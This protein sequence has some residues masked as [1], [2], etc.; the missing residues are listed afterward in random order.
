MQMHFKINRVLF[1]VA[2]T[3][4]M[5]AILVCGLTVASAAAPTPE[6]PLVLDIASTSQ[7][8]E[9]DGNFFVASTTNRLLQERLGGALQLNYKGSGQL[10]N[11]ETAECQGMQL[12]TIGGVTITLANIEA[13]VPQVAL[14]Y[15]PYLCESEEKAD[16]FLANAPAVDAIK[17]LVEKR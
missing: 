11:N 14:F 10:A 13:D 4:V 12:G 16:D 1:F 5:I 8:I 7:A 9:I 3:A 2:T 6:R 17:K 15:L